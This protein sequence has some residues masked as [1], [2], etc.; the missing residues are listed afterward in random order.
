[1]TLTASFLTKINIWETGMQIVNMTIP[2]KLFM[3]LLAL[4]LF[5]IDGQ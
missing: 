2:N 1:M 5:R 3:S 4:Y